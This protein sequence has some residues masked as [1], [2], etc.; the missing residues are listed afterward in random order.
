MLLDDGHQVTDNFTIMD[1]NDPGNP[2][3]A[4]Q[5]VVQLELHLGLIVGQMREVLCHVPPSQFSG[6]GVV[7]LVEN[8]D[9][10]ASSVWARSA[11]ISYAS[12]RI[13]APLRWSHHD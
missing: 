12:Q 1:G 9:D 8:L 2:A 6:G 11:S 7:G 5:G 10:H 3:S 13:A 4:G